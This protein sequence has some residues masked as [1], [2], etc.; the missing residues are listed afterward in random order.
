MKLLDFIL[1]VTRRSVSKR[2][3]LDDDFYFEKSLLGVVGEW[4]VSVD[5]REVI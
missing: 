5:S 1:R 4:R 2:D 3:A